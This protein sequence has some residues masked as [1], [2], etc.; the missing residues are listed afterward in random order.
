MNKFIIVLFSVVFSFCYP[1]FAQQNQTNKFVGAVDDSIVIKEVLLMPVL[2]NVSNIYAKPVEEA[3]RADLQ[4]DLKWNLNDFNPSSLQANT[5]WSASLFEDSKIVQDVAQKHKADAIL[6]LNITKGPNGLNGQMNLYLAKDGQLF[7]EDSF[8]SPSAF[9]TTEVVTFAKTA[10]AKIKE[11]IPYQGLI[12]SRKNQTVTL[13]MG[14]RDGLKINDELTVIHI[15]Q[16]NR[17]PKHKF[18]VSSEKEIIGRVKIFKVDEALSFANIILEKEAGVI[19]TGSKVLGKNFVS[20]PVPMVD[21]D[22]RLV[23][24]L[25]QRS[26]QDIAFGKNPKEWTYHQPQFG[27]LGLFVGNS[28]YNHNTKLTT[29]GGVPA[30]SAISPNI[31]VK[32][33]LWMTSDLILDYKIRQSV[34]SITNNLNGSSPRNVNM[35]LGQYGLALR[36]SLLMTDDFFGPKWNIGGGFT[37]TKFT[38]DDTSLD[39]Y[40]DNNFGGLHFNLGGQFPLSAEMPILFGAEFE[41]YITKTLSEGKSSGSPKADIVNFQIYGDYMMDAKTIIRGE[42]IFENYSGKMDGTGSRTYP[43]TSTSHR[44]TTFNLGYNWLF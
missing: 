15:I 8:K 27:R 34:F 22:G 33:E 12:L 16:L 25:S 6:S 23:E 18:V 39:T 35:S 2:D 19:H 20:Y 42:I 32:G 10:L 7:L 11:K 14:A 31:A 24:G 30:S 21:K 5:K 26:D 9:E 44:L 37:Q 38:V 36:T 43:A 40:T 28:F 41:Y 13:N 4:K 1:T 17:H 29:V 3:L